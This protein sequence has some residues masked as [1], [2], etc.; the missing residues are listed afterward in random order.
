MRE[1]DEKKR[2]HERCKFLFATLIK[3]W[4]F[5]KLSFSTW[6]HGW[7][8]WLRDRKAS[9]RERREESNSCPIA[10]FAKAARFSITFLIDFQR[11]G[12]T[13]GW[14]GQIIEALITPEEVL[15]MAESEPA[16][17]THAL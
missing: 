1:R 17:D 12:R 10:V 13:V 11:Q 6:T 4:H 8:A 16:A 15:T 9:A 3:K 5:R 14:G 7:L 2:A